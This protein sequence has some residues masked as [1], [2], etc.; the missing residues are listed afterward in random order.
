MLEFAGD[1]VIPYQIPILQEGNTML[2]LIWHA[3]F[4][5]GHLYQYDLKTQKENLFQEVLDNQDKLVT[6][7]LIN[8]LTGDVYEVDLS[9]G[10][11][12]TFKN[13]KPNNL[14]PRADMLRKESYTYRLIYFREVEKIFG[15]N[16]EKIGADK[17]IYFIGFQYTDE[18]EKNHKRI[19]KVYLDG[20]IVIN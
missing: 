18:N 12:T 20:Q 2:H 11:I 4:T 15:A 17:I 16:L 3:H 10:I 19:M 5:D 8:R 1:S 9:K 7:S 13:N 6:F 14:E